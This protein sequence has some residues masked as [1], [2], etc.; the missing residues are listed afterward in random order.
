MVL[1]F[2]FDFLG[3]R[4]MQLPSPWV[5]F[6]ASFVMLVV[7]SVLQTGFMQVAYQIYTSPLGFGRILHEIQR[8]HV[9]EKRHTIT[10]RVQKQGEPIAVSLVPALADNYQYVVLETVGLK[11]LGQ[12][13][14][15][16]SGKSHASASSTADAAVEPNVSGKSS[17][18]S[19][20]SAEPG[21]KSTQNAL[22]V[23]P[24]DAPRIMQEIEYLESAHGC[25]IR[26]SALL[27]TH[28]HMDHVGGA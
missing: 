28:Y 6:V 16:P 24:C 25:S 3:L 21:T 15:K 26:V 10:H 1:S 19:E 2:I 23:D 9:G 5:V 14:R 20:A 12:H 17:S 11:K 27:L 7:V 4:D 8:M 13:L 22:V 18:S